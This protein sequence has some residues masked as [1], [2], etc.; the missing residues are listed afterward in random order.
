MSDKHAVKEA[1]PTFFTQPKISTM[2]LDELRLEVKTLRHVV[3]TQQELL[4]SE[5]RKRKQADKLL[6]EAERLFNGIDEGFDE[7]AEILTEAEK[8]GAADDDGGWDD[9]DEDLE[10]SVGK[11]AD[12]FTYAVKQGV[13][14]V[15]KEAAHA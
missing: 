10:I 1:V 12:A 4:A 5:R 3:K 6:E 7:A 15:I 2:S 11:L 8:E 13:T 14:K 9:A